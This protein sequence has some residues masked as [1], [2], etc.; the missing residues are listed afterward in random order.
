MNSFKAVFKALEYE[1]HRQRKAL[2][3]GVRLIQETR[4]WVEEEGKTVSQRSKEF[5]HDYRYFPEPD[6]PPLFVSRQWVEEGKAQLAELPEA[7]RDRFVSEYGLPFYDANLLTNNK[8]MADYFEECLKIGKPEELP[9]TSRAKMASNWLLGEFNRLLNATNTEIPNTKITPASTCEI[10]RLTQ[11]G[12]INTTAAKQ[13]Y[14]FVFKTG[15]S[16]SAVIEQ[17]G[18]SQISDSGELEKMAEKVI[19]DNPQAVK[20][21]HA[22]KETAIKFLVGQLMRA[23]RGR[24]NPQIATQLLKNKLGEK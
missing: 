15:M 8:L 2:E 23:S 5:A 10:I 17:Q 1:A 11:E 3:D 13:V 9:L 12:V 16:V 4:G 6:L 14:E 21:F 7:R 22:G 24:A 18:L 19:M 20:D